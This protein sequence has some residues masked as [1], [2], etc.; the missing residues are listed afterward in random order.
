MDRLVPEQLKLR[1]VWI[2]DIHL[3][4]KDCKAAFLL[5]FLER[6]DCETLYLVRDIIDIWSLSRSFH[7]P[8][9]HNQVI[10]TIMRKARD[11]V[12][13][14]YIPGNHD[15]VFRD[16]VGEAFGA[17]EIHEQHV[18]ETADDRRLLVM[19]GDELDDLIRL[20]RFNRLIG[21]AAYDFLLF[22]NR[23]CH[24]LRRRFGY[25][26]WSLAGYIKSR[27]HNAGKAI[28]SF[29]Q[30]VLHYAAQQGYDG[31]VCGH[32]HHPE[33]RHE[34]GMLYCNDGDWIENCTALVET[35]DGRLEI[36]HWS[37]SYRKVKHLPAESAGKD[38]AMPKAVGQ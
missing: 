21:D 6:I 36:L 15:R 37:D 18:H 8:A 28:A 17:V 20:S 26:Y 38:R 29:E 25:S 27:I 32:I 31:V 16:Y 22:M 9:E 5:D 3:G 14:I 33:V 1:T 30:A 7:W 10:R 4:Y 12:R 2:S 35:R 23:V 24:S 11:G 13:V 34:N 19:H